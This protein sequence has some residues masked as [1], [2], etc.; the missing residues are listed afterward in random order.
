M[1][2]IKSLGNKFP[3]KDGDIPAQRHREITNPGTAKFG[4]ARHSGPN[5]VRA[6]TDTHHLM[7]AEGR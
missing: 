3:K 1:N 4:P 5:S 2:V 7:R 6:G